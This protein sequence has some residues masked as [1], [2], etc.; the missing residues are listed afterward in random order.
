MHDGHGRARHDSAVSV[1]DDALDL[2]RVALGIRR[3]CGETTAHDN[4]EGYRQADGATNGRISTHTILENDST[5]VSPNAASRRDPT[6][7]V[8]RL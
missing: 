6:D 2:A 1:F 4:A 7:E 3:R 8:E 5:L